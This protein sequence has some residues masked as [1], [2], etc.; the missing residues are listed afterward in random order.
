[1]YRPLPFASKTHTKNSKITQHKYTRHLIVGL[2]LLLLLLLLLFFLF[3]LF[4]AFK[5]HL[6]D[7][8][9]GLAFDRLVVAL[10][11]ALIKRELGVGELKDLLFDGGSGHKPK[12]ES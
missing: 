6:G 8:L 12:G 7:N 3:L 5:Q 1:M 4:I 9:L 10:A 2:N 11:D